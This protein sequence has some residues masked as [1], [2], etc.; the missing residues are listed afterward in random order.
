MED[1]ATRDM[2]AIQWMQSMQT[3]AAAFSRER[4]ENKELAVRPSAI[5]GSERAREVFS[6]ALFTS[7]LRFAHAGQGEPFVSYVSLSE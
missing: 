1:I 7:V 4:A 3:A 2:C 5:P 6:H